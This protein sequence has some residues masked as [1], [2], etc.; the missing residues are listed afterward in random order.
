MP[1]YEE[2]KASLQATINILND[3]YALLEQELLDTRKKLAQARREICQRTAGY[4]QYP[5]GA[6]VEAK[7]RGWDC[8]EERYDD[9]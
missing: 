8:W 4:S 9:N 3:E 1:T 5:H 2:D 6:H 7:M